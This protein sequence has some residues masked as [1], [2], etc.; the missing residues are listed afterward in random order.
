MPPNAV[1]QQHVAMPVLHTLCW[2]MSV[3]TASWL[4]ISLGIAG[5]ISAHSCRLT[6][7]APAVLDGLRLGVMPPLSLPALPPRLLMQLP[8]SWAMR[9]LLASAALSVAAAA[10]AERLV[11]GRA[12]AVISYSTRCE[13]SI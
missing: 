9:A 10:A 7:S 12:G 6:P 11:T 13:Q 8:T 5:K 4:P 2:L 3:S 1:Q